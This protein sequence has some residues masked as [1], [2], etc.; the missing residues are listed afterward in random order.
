MTQSQFSN[1][2]TEDTIKRRG[3]PYRQVP[4]Y[5]LKG[6]FFLAFWPF[7]DRVGKLKDISSDGVGFEYPLVGKQRQINEVLVVIF[8]SRPKSRYLRG[9]ACRVVYDIKIEPAAQKGVEI[10]RCGLQFT[11]LSYNQN[12]KLKDLLNRHVARLC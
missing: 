4:R 10:R 1:Y 2:V 9:L 12:S 7:L 6:K 11:K 5:A 3:G 8:S